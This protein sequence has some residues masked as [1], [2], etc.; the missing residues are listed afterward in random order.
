MDGVSVQNVSNR[1]RKVSTYAGSEQGYLDHQ[2]PLEAKF[3]GPIGL[4]FD[5]SRD[6]L[7]VADGFNNAIRKIDQHGVSTLAG[8]G[9]QNGYHDGNKEEA[10]FNFPFDIVH[11]L[12]DDVF[13]V[14]DYFNHRIRKVTPDG[15]VTTL[16]GSGKGASEDGQ[17]INASFHSP[18]GITIDQRSGCLYVANRYA[19]IVQK[20]TQQGVATTIAGK[21][22]EAG[23]DDGIGLRGAKLSG[24][25]GLC[26][27][28][29]Q[30]CLFIATGNGYS[31]RKLDLRSGMVTTVAGSG[32]QGYK[33]GSGKV[34]QF[35][36]PHNVVLVEDGSILVTDFTDHRIRRVIPRGDAKYDV[37]T[38]AGTG[39]AGQED[40]DEFRSSKF[41]APVGICIDHRSN[42]C[43][44]SDHFNHV[45]RK[46]QM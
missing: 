5:H 6:C 42:V 23:N 3:N 26:F 19:H 21:P 43:Y 12:A 32:Q 39:V 24:P 9:Q 2:S 7:L 22:G 18:T 27:S 41:N 16:A 11:Y 45:I 17:G 13:F 33:D 38:F 31:I 37:E 28:E 4:A 35:G 15:K 8:K 1:E 10:L 40:D 44:V 46:I 29:K 34:A 30:E 14:T 25:L 20:I 36:V